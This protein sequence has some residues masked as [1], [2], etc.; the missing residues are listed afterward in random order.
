MKRNHESGAILIMVALM[1]VVLMGMS[2]FA[3]DQGEAWYARTQAQTAADAGALAGAVALAK[4]N[5]TYPFPAGGIVEQ[6]ALTLATAPANHVRGQAGG[7][8]VD[9]ACPGWMTAPNNVDC[10]R[11]RVYRDGTNGGATFPTLFANVFGVTD[12]GVRATATAQV[13]VGN[14]VNCMKPFIVPDRFAGPN[15]PG[16]RY[17]PSEG[18]YYNDPN[19]VS[20]TGYGKDDIGNVIVLYPDSDK[21]PTPSF[22]QPISLEGANPGATGV[23]SMITGC[24]TRQ[25]KIGDFV[26]PKPGGGGGSKF[27]KAIDDIIALD[28]GASWNGTKVVSGCCDVSPRIVP[29]AIGNP[30]HVSPGRDDDIQIVNIFGFFLMES[31]AGDPQEM[32]RARLVQVEG[33]LVTG[34]TGPVQSS[35][36]FIPVITLVQ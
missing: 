14:A 7:V 23:E 25:Y 17:D 2:A 35:A 19:S 8:L 15:W 22:W 36:G 18:D 12:Q 24:T 32:I 1:L 3:I 27:R 30:A 10:V 29:V 5:P 31:Q 33:L 26:T 21:T 6:S 28:S 9:A 16:D 11:V 20:P 13:K 34:G 4:D